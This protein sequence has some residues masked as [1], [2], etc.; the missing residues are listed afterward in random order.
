MLKNYA[1][2]TDYIFK[3]NNTQVDIAKDLYIPMPMY[4][5]IEYNSNYAKTSARLW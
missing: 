1:S 4:N 5:L 2:V 3:T